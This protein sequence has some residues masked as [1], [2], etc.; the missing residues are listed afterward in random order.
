MA[1]I[2]PHKIVISFDEEGAFSKAIAMYRI[3]D[4]DGITLSKYKSISVNSEIGVAAMNTLLT[5][6]QTFLKN[7][8]GV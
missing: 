6:I 2:I 8:E 7:R 5:K 1:K 3:Q 4:N